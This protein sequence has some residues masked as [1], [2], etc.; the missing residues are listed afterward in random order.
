M[1]IHT[2]RTRINI[3]P[4]CKVCK[5]AGKSRSVYTSHYTRE[6]PSRQSKVVCPLLLS[7][8]CNY[9]HQPGHTIR[10][11]SILRKYKKLNNDNDAQIHID[12]EK[13]I[14]IEDTH[15]GNQIKNPYDQNHPD[16]LW[17]PLPIQPTATAGATTG[18][19]FNGDDFNWGFWNSYGNGNWVWRWIPTIQGGYHAN[20]LPGNT[21]QHHNHNHSPCGKRRR[22]DSKLEEGEINHNEDEDHDELELTG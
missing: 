17:F 5:D 11:C 9:C 2:P 18:S 22:I 7:Q 6:N 14:R 4:F 16:T 1:P 3:K 15:L 19:G 8:T 20:W 13:E 21:Q 12:I 10:Y